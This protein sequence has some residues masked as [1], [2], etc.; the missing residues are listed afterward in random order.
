MEDGVSGR[1]VFSHFSFSEPGD[2]RLLG[3]WLLAF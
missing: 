3:W 1:L 2:L